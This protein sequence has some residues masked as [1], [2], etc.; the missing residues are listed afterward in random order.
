M[1]YYRITKYNPEFRN[2]Q[3]F[4]TKNDWTSISDIGQVF[5]EGVLTAEDYKQMEDS[6][7]KALNIVLQTK[8]VT[9][10]NIYKLEKYDCIDEYIFSHKEKDVYAKLA[11]SSCI[12]LDKVE[13]VTRLILREL[14]WCTLSCR[15]KSVEIEFGYDYY[16]Y[17]RCDEID[18][19]TQQEILK[20][21]LFVEL[22]SEKD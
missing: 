10:M 21:G 14:I 3:G 12:N 13:T 15:T 20:C 9:Q 11:D 4:Y 2:E 22:L 5:D 6:Y 1:N 16:M 7:I 19:S 18:V 8:D 17:V